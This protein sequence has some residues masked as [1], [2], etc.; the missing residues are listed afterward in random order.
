MAGVILFGALLV[1][2]AVAYVSNW[3]ALKPWRDSANAHWTEQAR[4]SYPVRK[5]AATNLLALPASMVMICVFIDPETMPPWWLVALFA[6]VGTIAGTVPMDLELFPRYKTPDLLRT[7][8][9]GWLMRSVLVAGF[10]VAAIC[11]PRELNGQAAIVLGALVLF[12]IAWSYDGWI[13][14]GKLF[15]LL[16]PADEKLRVLVEDESRQTGI[17]VRSVLLIK[18]EMSLAYA[19]PATK[20]VLFTTRLMNVLSNDEVR[21]VCAHELAHLAERPAIIVLRHAMWFVFLP[22]VLFKPVFVTYG[23]AGCAVLVA[24]SL[25]V[26]QVMMRVSRALEKRADKVATENQAEAGVYARALLALYKDNLI[27]AVLSR[28]RTHP[29]LYDRMLAAGI[30][31]DFP[32]P[33]A[34]GSLGANGYAVWILFGVLLGVWLGRYSAQRL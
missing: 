7:I 9:L 18:S 13:R 28:R 24:I 27:P 20:T 8:A 29:D 23:P 31:P 1:A 19:L 5:G 33:R 32:K 4:L 25:G 12:L 34:A 6:M 2:A 30:T 16:K 11:M 10:V 22:W 14:L 26:Q 3:L 15:G 21:S 17:R